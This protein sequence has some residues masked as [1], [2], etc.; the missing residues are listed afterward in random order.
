MNQRKIV[1][2]TL[3]P[4]AIGPYSQAVIAQGFLYMSGQLGIDPAT[5]AMVESGREEQFEQIFKNAGHILEAAGCGFKDVVK[6]TGFLTDM[7]D[8]PLFNKVYSRYFQL[9]YPARSVFEVSALPKKGAFA[10]LELVAKMT[11]NLSF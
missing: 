2:T 9:P 7:D 8:F 1:E 3:A 4:P 10:E 6:C 11:D 5:G